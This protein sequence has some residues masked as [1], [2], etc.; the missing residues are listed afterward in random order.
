VCGLWIHLASD[1]IQWRALVN[2]AMNLDCY[3]LV[4]DFVY[5]GRRLSACQRKILLPFSVLNIHRGQNR[6]SRKV[7]NLQVS[8]KQEFLY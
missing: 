5:S 8:R 2:M 3:I 6:K 4:C 1:R 7:K